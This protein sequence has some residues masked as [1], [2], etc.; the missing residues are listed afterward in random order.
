MPGPTR[1][2]ISTPARSRHSSPSSRGRSAST[3]ST[4][5]SPPLTAAPSRRRSRPAPPSSPRTT[6]TAPAARPST[7]PA[8]D[9]V[10]VADADVSEGEG[11]RSVPRRSPRTPSPARGTRTVSLEKREMTA[12]ET[13]ARV[14]RQVVVSTG[15][16]DVVRADVP[17]P[18]PGE[19][20]VRSVLAGVCGSDTHAAAG[21][22]P[23]ISLPYVPGHEVVG[24][25]AGTGAGV[26]SVQ[27]GERV[28]VEPYL[29]CWH[30]KQCLRGQENICENL[31]FL[32]CGDPQ[33]AMADYFTVD[34]RRI[35]VIPDELD[36]HAAALI[37]PLST[38]VHAVRLA[39]GVVG[40]TV[41]VLGAGSIGLLLLRTV[42]AQGATRVVI[43]APRAERRQLALALGA[44][45]AVDAFADD[46]VDQVRTALGESA[47]VVFDCVAN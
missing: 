29:P 3:G 33:G 47:D 8:A 28:T 34:A 43:T 11:G 19:G 15:R 27:P 10:G 30:C 7:S 39:G 13:P 37:E 4:W 46:A 25:V 45:A 14:M 35:H 38:P 41:A 5:P 2:R 36:D 23:W 21:H 17:Q 22:H 1:S 44:D 40:R 9:V 18:G 26:S 20:L 32:G 16:I 6:S 12:Q 42:V 24:V 31:G